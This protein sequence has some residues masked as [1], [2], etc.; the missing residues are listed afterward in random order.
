[1]LGKL[2]DFLADCACRCLI[3]SIDAIFRNDEETYLTISGLY[4]YDYYGGPLMMN[5]VVA[6][7]ILLGLNA[8]RINYAR[9]Q[10]GQAAAW[11]FWLLVCGA[12]L[13]L[14]NAPNFSEG[15]YLIGEYTIAAFMRIVW[16]WLLINWTLS[17]KGYSWS[18][19]PAAPETHT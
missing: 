12:D 16:F 19:Y 11:V 5:I 3:L 14:L 10:F 13:F 4:L 7:G 9:K 6:V 8:F 17:S 18:M 1:M 2:P 15:V